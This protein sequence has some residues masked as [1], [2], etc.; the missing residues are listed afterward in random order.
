MYGLANFI[1]Q[2][3]CAQK[4]SLVRK[5]HFSKIGNGISLRLVRLLWVSRR[6]PKSYHYGLFIA[7]VFQIAYLSFVRNLLPFFISLFVLSGV[8]QTGDIPFQPG[9]VSGGVGGA[10]AA[11]TSAWSPLYNP[12]LLPW[13]KTSSIAVGA[14][15]RFLTAGT[16]AQGLSGIFKLKRSAFG[17]G[18]VSHGYS[19]YRRSR[20]GLSY[21][22]MLGNRVS[23]GVTIHYDALSLGNN[24]G[25]AGAVSAT[26]GVSG[27]ISESFTVG[28]YVFNPLRVSFSDNVDEYLPTVM[29]VGA[30]YT[31]SDKVMVLVD[32]EKDINFKPGLKLGID[33]KPAD[34]LHVRGGFRTLPQSFTFGFGL[35]L[36]RFNA[37]LAAW[38]HPVLGTSPMLSLQYDFGK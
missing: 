19:A 4:R 30:A 16:H 9:A 15:N 36:P 20:V 10:Q 17:L 34:I 31:F 28:A 12:G 11:L 22:L 33:Y 23:A 32:V 26:V 2:Y 5:A 1:V 37:D 3:T 14:E 29:A 21:G 24:Y 25:S 38:V 8:A 7:P 13:Q 18:I 6:S 27:K 35:D